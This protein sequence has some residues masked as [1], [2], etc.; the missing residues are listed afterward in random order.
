MSPSGPSIG[1]TAIGGYLG[2]GKTTLVNEMLAA[3]AGR[4][5]GVIVNDF[6]S[7]AIDAD[8][9][10]S[11]AG[12]TLALTNGCVCCSLLDGFESALRT[13]RDHSPRL[14]HVVVE[15]SGVGDPHQ[16]AQWGHTPGFDGGA[17]IVVADAGAVRRQARDR[18]VGDAVTAQ[19]RSADLIVITKGELV[20]AV[21]W[22]ALSTWLHEIADAPIVEKPVPIDVV[23]GVQSTPDR[24]PAGDDATHPTHLTRTVEVAAATNEVGLMAWL[25]AAPVDVVRVK[26]FVGMAAD[27]TRHWTVQ[28]VGRRATIRP[29]AGS[30]ESSRLV[31]VALPGTGE[32]ELDGWLAAAPR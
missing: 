8:L 6:G 21:E 13:L 2:A 11:H 29:S 27:A 5:L 4:R 26:G 24:S 18:R 10:E 23:L 25:D 7:I 12:E 15:V 20:D 22:R 31:I 17:T 16:V 28:R 3:P 19:L 30:I 1:F 32:A 14:D 9:I